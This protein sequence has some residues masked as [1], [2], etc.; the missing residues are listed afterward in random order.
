MKCV[1]IRCDSMMIFDNLMIKWCVLSSCD[2]VVMCDNVLLYD[3][4]VCPQM[5]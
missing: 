3:I 4:V 1:L 5:V 2:D